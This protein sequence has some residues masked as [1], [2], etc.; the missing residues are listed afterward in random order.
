MEQTIAPASK[1]AAQKKLY[2]TLFY[3]LLASNFLVGLIRHLI[4]PGS[5]A[6]VA[7]AALLLV[8]IGLDIWFAVMT[9]RLARALGY[10]TPTTIALL[11]MSVLP[12]VNLVV[13]YIMTRKY[14]KVTGAQTNFFM[15]DAP[16]A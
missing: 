14:K 6:A 1:L 11:L 13:V 3:V 12:A 2:L 15:F 5:A 10:T 8:Q 16:T 9:Y 4:L 7:E